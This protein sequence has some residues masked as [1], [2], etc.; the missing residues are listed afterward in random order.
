MKI[1]TLNIWGTF[2]PYRARWKYLLAELELLQADLLFLQEVS[3]QECLDQMMEATRLPHS[4]I[5]LEAGLAI[6]SRTP[7]R[8]KTAHMYKA[9]SSLENYKRGALVC[10]L[11]HERQNLTVATTHLSW[12]AEDGQ[13]RCQ[14]VAEFVKIVSQTGSPA[15]LAGDFN[16]IP[17]SAAIQ[18]V[19]HAGYCDLFRHVNPN[20]PGITWDNQNPFIQG[21]SVKFPNRRIDYVFLDQK[22][23]SQAVMS[24]AVAYNRP[25]AAN[26][27]PSDHYGLFAEVNM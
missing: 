21:H 20:H 23:S 19:L 27:Y 15:I 13:A 18:T 6:L 22:L 8:A 4:A 14:Q 2:G 7:L 11:E 17:E 12:K 3:H 16:D 25:N 26:M 1:S 5:S 24:C 10:I 9:V